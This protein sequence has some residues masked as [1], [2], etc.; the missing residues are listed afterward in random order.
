MRKIRSKNPERK[1]EIND[2]VTSYYKEYHRSPTI[3]EIARG[4]GAAKSTV[5]S[6]LIEMNHEN[7]I[8][9]DGRTIETV[10]T[11][12]FNSTYFSAPIVGSI[13]CGS[14]TYEEENIE[15]Y[16]SLPEA[17]FGKGEFFILRAHGDSM[18]DSDINEGDL[19][20]IRKQKTASVGDIV[21]ALDESGENTLKKFA[22][23]DSVTHEAILEYRNQSK[24]P[25]KIIRVN[26]LIVQ[27]VAK[28][29]IKAL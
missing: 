20:V 13:P 11:G 29:I 22:G 18:I 8:S 7:S 26:N 27:G 4:I 24:Y 14:P 5:H 3:S 15:E 23:I 1:R 12:K 16:V 2:F 10:T 19:V 28:H 21:V 9:Y 6:Y 25:G 17:I